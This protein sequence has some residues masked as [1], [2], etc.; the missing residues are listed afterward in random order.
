MVDAIFLLLFTVCC[1][2]QWLIFVLI[3]IAGQSQSNPGIHG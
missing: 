2:S 1:Y 3:Q